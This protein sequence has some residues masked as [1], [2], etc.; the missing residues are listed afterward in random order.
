MTCNA[1]LRPFHCFDQDRKDS[2]VAIISSF[3]SSLRHCYC[4]RA[5]PKKSKLWTSGV[6]IR[7]VTAAISSEEHPDRRP[8]FKLNL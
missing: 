8:H 1:P 3:P 5:T 7:A 4:N 2:C 6:H